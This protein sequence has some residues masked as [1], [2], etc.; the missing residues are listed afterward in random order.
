[1]RASFLH[2]RIAFIHAW[3][4]AST[5]YNKGRKETRNETEEG[6]ESMQ[7]IGVADIF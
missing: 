6:N 1:M 5:V 4:H 2:D 7:L 3:S